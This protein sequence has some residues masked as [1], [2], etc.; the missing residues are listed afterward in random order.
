SQI[1]RKLKA[2]TTK[3]ITQYIREKRLDEAMKMLQKGLGTAAEISYRVGFNSPTYFNKCFHDYFGYP[4]G[5][6]TRQKEKSQKTALSKV[7]LIDEFENRPAGGLGNAAGII[8]VKSKWSP[9]AI[10]AIV[11]I[12]GMSVLVSYYYIRQSRPFKGISAHEGEQVSVVVIPFK[13]I[14]KA[15]DEYIAQGTYEE[16]VKKL[17]KVGKLKVIAGS[18]VEK[19]RSS[20]MT[21]LSI[22]SKFKADYIIEGSVWKEEEKFRLSVVMTDIKTGEEIF[23]RDYTRDYTLLMDLTSEVALSLVENVQVHLLPDEIKQLSENPTNYISA[24]GLNIRA[25]EAW[26][27]GFRQPSTQNSSHD[28]ALQLAKQAIRLDSMFLPPYTLIASV[29]YIR[30]DMDSAIQIAQMLIDKFPEKS[31][32]Y[33]TMGGIYMNQKQFDKSLEMYQK[34]VELSDVNS[35]WDHLMMG[36]IHCRINKDYKKGLALMIRGMQFPVFGDNFKH[37]NYFTGPLKD[38]GLYEESYKYD[39]IGFA[40]YLGGC[41][42]IE[43]CVES[44]ILLYN[45]EGALP[46]LDSLCEISVCDNCSDYYAMVYIAQRD[47]AKISGFTNLN[48]NYLE[49]IRLLKNGNVEKGTL[50]LNEHISD[51]LK[52]NPVTDVWKDLEYIVAACYGWLGDG[53]KALEWLE[54][55]GERGF[56]YGKH[57]FM[58]IDPAFDSIREDPRFMSIYEKAQKEKAEIREEIQGMIERGELEL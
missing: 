33:T 50:V 11:I 30:G 40:N 21:P 10:V 49:G 47:Y 42:V 17:K 38:I 27:T 39:K 58:M 53:E 20:G 43:N 29:F 31:E 44:H 35:Q 48:D 36:R 28:R 9:L 16:V 12:V 8:K 5:E 15:E 56:W 18:E 6:V 24:Y 55:T 34:S 41:G 3:S 7:N 13:N 22:G 25:W 51:I 2:L 45:L 19:H 1:H 23:A 46:L 54:K 26:N 52:I 37:Y 32:G 4:P 14:S 57:D